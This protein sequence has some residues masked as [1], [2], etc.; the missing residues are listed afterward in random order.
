MRVWVVT[1]GEYSDRSIVAIK[2]N[3]EAARNLMKKCSGCNGTGKNPYYETE[4]CW[5][6]QE[7]ERPR[8]DW[9]EPLTFEIE[10][11]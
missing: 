9:N 2:S 10:D 4:P 1:K 7:D 6:C 8:D 5:D 11:E 3:E